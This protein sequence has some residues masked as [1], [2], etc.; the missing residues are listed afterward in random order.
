[1]LYTFVL[2]ASSL[3][4]P[5]NYFQSST[6]TAC[7]SAAPQNPQFSTGLARF[8][9]DFTSEGAVFVLFAASSCFDN[10]VPLQ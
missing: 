6:S 8:L 1:M 5:E 3:V 10:A 2:T 9:Q 7:S 4:F